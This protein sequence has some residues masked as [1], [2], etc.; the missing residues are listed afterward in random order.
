MAKEQKRGR[1]EKKKK[2][3]TVRN[4]VA[5]AAV[6]AVLAWLGVHFGG[7]GF[8]LGAGENGQGGEKQVNATVDVTE[9]AA[10]SE[11]SSDVEPTEE[12]TEESSSSEELTSIRICISD[13]AISVENR[14][15]TDAAALK[16]YILSVYEDGMHIELQ[17][18]HA[19]KLTYDSVKQMLDELDYP[20]T[21]TQ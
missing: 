10:E 14:R 17:D 7:L 13:E 4:T 11:Q 16:E 6:L 20:Y 5:A 21:E 9:Q 15:F 2:R 19:V 1:Q 18:S 12:Q 8:G 3:H